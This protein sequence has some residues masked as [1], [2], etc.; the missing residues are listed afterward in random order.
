MCRRSIM[1]AKIFLGG[2][3]NRRCRLKRATAGRVDCHANSSRPGAHR[4]D[5]GVDTDYYTFALSFSRCSFS[6]ALRLSLILL[7]SSARTLTRI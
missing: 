7:P 5:R 1:S 4:I 6:T 2:K 3:L